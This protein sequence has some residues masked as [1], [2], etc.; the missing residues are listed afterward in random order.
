MLLL[1]VVSGTSAAGTTGR[2]RTAHL[3]IGLLA[4]AVLVWTLL[5]SPKSDN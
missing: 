3:V 5:R 4:G 2:T 1:L